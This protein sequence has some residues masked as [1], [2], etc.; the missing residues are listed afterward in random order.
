MSE[1]PSPHS[2]VLCVDDHH[3]VIDA[4][5]ISLR[6][7][8]M[9][10]RVDKATSLAGALVA[11]E[12]DPDCALV[13]LDLQMADAR[14]MEAVAM[15]RERFPDVPII[16]FTGEQSP[17]VV[18]AA[19][20]AGVRGYVTKNSPLEVVMGAIRIVLSGGCY[21]PSQLMSLLGLAASARD[22]DAIAP[23]SP[24]YLTQRQH[25]VLEFLLD[26]MPNKVIAARLGMAE[27]TV[28]SHLSTI[29]RVIGARNRA[30]AILR[31]RALGMI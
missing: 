14:G 18:A 8:G 3:V 29:Y 22:G 30:Q 2:R 28:K 31:A 25:Q 27:G 1:T 12:R 11:L 10:A 20:D 16:V 23:A 19:F 13:V 6:A 4:L 5:A 21:I 15:L 17:E 7:A 24:P 9:F 26:G